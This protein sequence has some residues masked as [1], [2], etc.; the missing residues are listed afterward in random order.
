MRAWSAD[1]AVNPAVALDREGD[2]PVAKPRFAHSAPVHELEFRPGP[3]SR[4]RDVAPVTQAEALRS[5]RTSRARA[6]FALSVSMAISSSRRATASRNSHGAA[7]MACGLRARTIADS[8]RAES[9]AKRMSWPSCA[10]HSRLASQAAAATP[11]RLA[12][13]IRST[14][15][16]RVTSA[17]RCFSAASIHHSSAAPSQPRDR[18]ADAARTRCGLRRRKPRASARCRSCCASR[19][20][21]GARVRPPHATRASSIAASRSRSVAIP[22]ILRSVIR[23]ARANTVTA[24]RDGIEAHHLLRVKRQGLNLQY[25]PDLIR[26]SLKRNLGTATP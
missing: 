3:E 22:S 24:E 19:V 2:G 17:R 15:S 7:E 12:S 21:C 14:S 9:P 25:A 26:S 1:E 5:A 11:R 10:R 20:D 4:R 6:A 16:Q 23:K 18:G 13:A 8:R